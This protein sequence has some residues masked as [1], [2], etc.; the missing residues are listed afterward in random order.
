MCSVVAFKCVWRVSDSEIERAWNWI[1]EKRDECDLT[2]SKL[3][4]VCFFFSA[5]STSQLDSKKRKTPQR[6]QDTR[7]SD[8]SSVNASQLSSPG[9]QTFPAISNWVACQTNNGSAINS[10]KI[11]RAVTSCGLEYYASKASRKRNCHDL[12]QLCQV[13]KDHKN[14]CSMQ[15]VESSYQHCLG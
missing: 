15:L 9:K 8:E 6:S 12:S 4:E 11:Q 10:L 2:L 1:C 7:E 5:I 14:P 13:L 3:K